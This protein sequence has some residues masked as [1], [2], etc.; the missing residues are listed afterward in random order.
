[1]KAY[2]VWP[3]ILV[4]LLTFPVIAQWEYGGKWI[5]NYSSGTGLHM[6]TDT[7]SGNT[8][9]AWNK[10]NGEIRIYS[11]NVSTPLVMPFGTTGVRSYTPMIFICNGMCLFYLTA[12]AECL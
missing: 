2:W 9:I 11:Y 5:G 12:K 1:M 8:F 4:T 6:V 10:L 3:I 7:L